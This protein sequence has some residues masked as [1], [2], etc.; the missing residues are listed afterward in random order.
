[1]RF[2]PASRLQGSASLLIKQKAA[3]Q[4]NIQET[5]GRLA[6][7]TNWDIAFRNR[8]GALLPKFVIRRSSF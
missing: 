1:M 4:G 5:S 7:A 3:A 2:S 8:P 6:D